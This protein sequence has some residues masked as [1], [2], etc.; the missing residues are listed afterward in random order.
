MGRC[1]LDVFDPSCRWLPFYMFD[2]VMTTT[3]LFGH[4]WLLHCSIIVGVKRRAID[5]LFGS[6]KVHPARPHLL[7]DVVLCGPGN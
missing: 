7:C 4:K 2:L 1:T 5:C 6:E 3:L